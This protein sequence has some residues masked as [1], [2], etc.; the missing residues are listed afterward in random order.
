MAAGASGDIAKHIND[1]SLVKSQATAKM[2]KQSGE[3]NDPLLPFGS[4]KES[5]EDGNYV[6]YRY[7][8]F[9]LALYCFAAMI[10]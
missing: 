10:N 5:M 4:A 2:G 7:R 6:L 1:S 8:F 3:S 9:N